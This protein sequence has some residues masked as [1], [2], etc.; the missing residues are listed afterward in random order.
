MS[1][2]PPEK[3]IREWQRAFE[4]AHGT[5]NIPQVRYQNGW[6]RIQGRYA[7]MRECDMIKMT[8]TLKRR[9]ETPSKEASQ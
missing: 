6:F 7:A 9:V 1:I 2:Q 4:K 5:L 3:T 8:E